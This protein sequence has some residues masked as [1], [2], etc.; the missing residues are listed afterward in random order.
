[1]AIRKKLEKEQIF[2]LAE[3]GYKV[4]PVRT[5]ES[6]DPYM[7][8]PDYRITVFD[9][10]RHIAIGESYMMD[11]KTAEMFMTEIKEHLSKRGA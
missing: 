6:S 1:M 11:M 10:S 9:D 3:M 5:F 8:D 2:A 4:R 7:E